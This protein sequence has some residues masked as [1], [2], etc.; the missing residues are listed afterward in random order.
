MQVKNAV[1]FPDKKH[2]ALMLFNTKSIYHEAD[3]RSIDYPGHG[4]P[5]HTETFDNFEYWA[6]DHNDVGRAE[7]EKKI[8]ELYKQTPNRRDVVAFEADSKM[9][10][11]TKTVVG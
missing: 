4:Y 3:Q 2:Y 10:I 8:D 1:N 6:Y 9:S 5:A 11:A 7:W